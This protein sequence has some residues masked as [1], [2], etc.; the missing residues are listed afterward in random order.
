V[1]N[2][3][4]HLDRDVDD[5]CEGAASLPDDNDVDGHVTHDETGIQSAPESAK[6]KKKKSR[7]STSNR[8][9]PPLTRSKNM[10]VAKPKK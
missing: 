6:Q 10:V 1:L 4:P 5:R 8:P 9:F 7:P 2:I 3:N